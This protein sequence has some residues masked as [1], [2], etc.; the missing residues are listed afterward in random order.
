HMTV[1]RPGGR[2]YLGP[3]AGRRLYQCGDGWLCIATDDAT[4]LWALAG[5]KVDAHRA[6]D[7]ADAERIAK[8]L[9]DLARSDALARLAAL[10]VPAAPCLDFAEILADEHVRAN[11]M[12]V[13]LDDPT[14][15]AVTLGG[16]LIDFEATPIR[17]R[18]TGP[19]HGAHS[20]EVLAEAG[21]DAQHIA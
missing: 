7:G 13:T 10:G 9:H 8:T 21:Y 11:D 4:G 2:D 19:G 12:L 6:S 20:R 18:R 5:T 14:L 16:P 15:G 3:A 17:Y 1:P